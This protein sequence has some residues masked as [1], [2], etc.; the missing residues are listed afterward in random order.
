MSK[1]QFNICTVFPFLIVISLAVPAIIFKCILRGDTP[2][3]KW[4]Y[5]EA[6][7]AL[8][9]EHKPYRKLL[10]RIFLVLEKILMFAGGWTIGS[11]LFYACVNEMFKQ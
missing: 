10:I 1:L 8:Q 6:Q 2:F 9:H 11:A 7:D 5:K 3:V 4:N